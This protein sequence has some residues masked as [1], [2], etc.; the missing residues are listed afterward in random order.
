MRV[1]ISRS[2]EGLLLDVSAEVQ[3]QKQEEHARN[4][5]ANG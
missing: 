2:A 1:R 3:V 5:P 4:L